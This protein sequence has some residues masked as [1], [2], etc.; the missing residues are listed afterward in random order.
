MLWYMF[1]FIVIFIILQC[2]ANASLF[3]FETDEN[4]IICLSQACFD[5]NSA[6]DS[7]TANA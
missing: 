7:V 2:E 6:D 4:K 1:S 3:T 5:G